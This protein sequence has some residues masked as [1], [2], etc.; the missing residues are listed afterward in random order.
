VRA[1]VLG[2]S[3]SRIGIATGIAY[4]FTRM[5]LAMAAAVA[6][7]QQSC[8]GRFT[9]GLGA[10]TRGIRR[11]YGVSDWG[12][13]APQFADYARLLRKLLDADGADVEHKG[14]FYDLR[15]PSYQLPASVPGTKIY[16]SGVNGVMLRYSAAACDGVGIHGLAAAKGYLEE[17][18]LP[19]IIAGSQG[20]ERHVSI[21]CWQIVS[22]DANEE[23][24]R[25]R[26]RY[27]LAFYISTPS[28][29]RVAEACGWPEIAERVQ[30]KA[31][32]LKYADWSAIAREI[33]DRLIDELTVT[34]T[35][36]QV[37]AQLPAVEQRLASAGIDEVAYQLVGNDLS[38]ADTAEAGRLLVR[39]CAPEP[40][41]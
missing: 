27:Q 34:G 21:A 15:A 22:V 6:E 17:V 23:V 14:E 7:A 32:D 11:R 25:E 13:A 37:R 3:T 38:A 28:Y 39:A 2:A 5:P 30:Q 19:A 12:R 4:A 18:A 36:E 41:I 26:V 10:G 24:A 8:H 20:A 35:P 40:A 33:P 29:R 16:G 9:L 31:A 1:A